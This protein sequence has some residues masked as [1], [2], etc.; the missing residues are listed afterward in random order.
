MALSSSPANRPT[1]P[2]CKMA[3]RKEHRVTFECGMSPGWVA[4]A[5][6]PLKGAGPSQS[7]AVSSLIF[8]PPTG[9]EIFDCTLTSIPALSIPQLLQVNIFIIQELQCTFQL[10]MNSRGKDMLSLKLLFGNTISFAKP[11]TGARISFYQRIKLQFKCQPLGCS[12]QIGLS[13]WIT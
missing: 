3:P 13:T 2:S 7:G 6:L 11:G 5:R 8:C 10:S 1:K 4:F 9:K 12:N